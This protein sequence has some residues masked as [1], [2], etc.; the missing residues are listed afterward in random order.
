MKTESYLK[1]LLKAYLLMMIV[2]SISCSSNNDG[3]EPIEVDNESPSKPIGLTASN[4]TQRSLDLIWEPA[5]DNVKVKNYWLY[6][7]HE[8]LVGSGK[9]SYALEGLDPGRTYTYQI[10]ANDAAGNASELSDPLE[11]STMELL[12]AELQY[13]SGNLEVYLGALM[14]A[15]PGV[16]GNN[17]K[18][19]TDNDLDQ[20]GLIIHAILEDN[21]EEAVAQ[22]V[23]LNYQVVEFTDTESTP[24]QVY[25]ILKEFSIRTNYWGTFVFSKTP[26]KQNLVLAA[27]HILHDQNTGY[28]AAYVFRQ[29][30]AKA[31][32]ISGAHR[33]NRE[34]P[35]ECSGTTKACSSNYA[36]YRVSDVPHNIYSTFQR[37]TEIMYNELPSSVFVQLH[38]FSKEASDPYVIMSNGT[39]KTPSK[40]YVS[41]IKNALLEEDNTLTFKIPHLDANWTRYAAFDNTQGRFINGSPNPCSVEATGTTGRFVH[42]EQESSKLRASKAGWEK[43]SNALGKVF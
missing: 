21:I 43:V 39:N 25:Y 8:F 14:D 41:L 13:D 1:N 42:I 15:V 32:F 37:T 7:D 23:Y 12:T 11:V 5:T 16:S 38:G 29:N 26:K 34:E 27:P 28:Q 30:V 33:C 4:I 20:W 19:P 2:G 6:Q 3:N 24:N 40:D 31:L 22:A 17:Y 18:V 10:Q 36:P 35:T 9:A